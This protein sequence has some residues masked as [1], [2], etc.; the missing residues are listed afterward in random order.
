MNQLNGPLFN[1]NS[2]NNENNNS[3]NEQERDNEWEMINR[4]NNYISLN[5]NANEN[6]DLIR[7]RYITNLIIFFK[8]LKNRKL[9]L[10]LKLIIYF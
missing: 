6:D 8:F 9:I 2:N 5:I 7:R 1:D 3:N 4:N 10:N